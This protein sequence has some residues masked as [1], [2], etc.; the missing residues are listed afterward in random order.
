MNILKLLL[1][2]TAVSLFAVPG[3]SS[4]MD[5]YLVEL[6]EYF[7]GKDHI[8][9]AEEEFKRALMLNPSNTEAKEYLYQIRK[10]KISTTLDS[11]SAPAEAENPA[12]LKDTPPAK[13]TPKEPQYFYP[14]AGEK[15]LVQTSDKVRVSKKEVPKVVLEPKQPEKEKPSDLT[16][17]G[18]F[19][20]GF[21]ID[22]EGDF[23][24]KRANWDL[25]ELDWRILSTNAYD[26]RYNTYD[27]AIY[28][29]LRLELDG[30]TGDDTEY[31]CGFH[32][33]IDLSPWSFIG[34]TDK[35]TITGTGT[36]DI[37]EAQILYWAAT[38]Y[39]RRFIP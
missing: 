28:T 12:H 30:E 17:S 13:T 35:I 19:Q 29:R 39:I 4:S 18:E 9:N 37:A 5:A 31:S 22:S 20:T 16:L 3:F 10:K 33:N 6:G 8:Q 11:L 1:I 21:G 15:V 27:P 7:L 26:Q 24:W 23:I 25:N 38:G 34:K 2:L 36:S 14:Q 32:A